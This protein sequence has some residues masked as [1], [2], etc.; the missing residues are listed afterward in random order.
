MRSIPV[1]FLLAA[2]T[3]EAQSEEYKVYSEAPR[4]LLIRQGLRLVQRERERQSLRWQPFETLVA[5]GAAMPE[6]GFAWALYYRVTGQANWG[7]KAVDWALGDQAK[8]LRQLALV[9]DWCGPVIA[10]TQAERLGAKLERALAAAPSGDARQ[11]SARAFAAIALADRLPDQG[12]SVLQA[13]VEQ[14]WRGNIVKKIDA[15]APAIPR[16]QIYA[17]FELLH[18]VRDNLQIDLREDAPEYFKALPT[19]HLV[20]HY[21]APFPAPENEYRVPVY[22]RDG[23]PDLNDAALS[24]AA[25]L[26]MVAYDANSAENQFLQGWLMQDRFLM[27]GGFGLPYEFLWANPYQ[28]GLSY[29][30]APLVYHDSLTGHLF[31]RTSWDEN[32][33]WLGYFDG[34]LQFFRDGKIETLKPGAASEPVHVGEAV[35]LTARETESGRFRG[36]AEAVFILKLAPRARYLVEIDDQELREEETDTGGT[37]VL[38]IPEG[39]E[40]GIRLRRRGD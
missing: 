33:N 21:P 9:F 17:L 5:G 34:Q 15:G 1:I 8:D 18:A 36:D 2:A 20:S 6:P 26:A 14:W 13:I 39:I 35:I 16:D 11:Q 12:A 37:L 38:A 19:D 23:E 7:Q 30:Q 4:L 40:T 25:E 22:V 31:A 10:E 32:A 29:F 24:R 3:L 28:P 27:R